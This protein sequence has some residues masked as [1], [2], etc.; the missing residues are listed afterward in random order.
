[1]ATLADLAARI[2][3]D[4][5]RSDL[6]SQIGAAIRDAVDHYESERF[7]FNEAIGTT[8][9]LSSSVASIPLASLPVTFSRIDRIRIDDGGADL[10]DLVPR[11][12][13]WLMAAQDV[14]TV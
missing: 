9:T 12:Y 11:D 2:A 1:M 4:L 14:R 8:A 6:A 13:A 7:I 3:D 10:V 5:D